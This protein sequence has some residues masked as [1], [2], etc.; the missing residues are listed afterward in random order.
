MIPI[1]II[2]AIFLLVVL[3][4]FLVQKSL[5]LIKRVIVFSIFFLL[6][7]L[8]MFPDVST[9]IAHLIGVGRG[10]DLIFYFSHLFLLL[11]IITLWR[12]YSDL[13]DSI[14]KLS[15]II[16]MQNAGRPDKGNSRPV[17][18]SGERVG[19]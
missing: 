17:G 10:V 11:L 13:M 2:L 16:A 4:A 12:R 7:L 3:R 18:E 6:L 14:T 1:K 19:T 8:V 15:R 5:M 9:R